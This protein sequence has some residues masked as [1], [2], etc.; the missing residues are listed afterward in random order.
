MSVRSKN[1]K[2]PTDVRVGSRVRVR[3]LMLAMTQEKLAEGLGVSFQQVQNYENGTN[4]I[5]A[6]RLVRVCEILSIS[7]TFVFDAPTSEAK[8]EGT[9][10]EDIDSF[11]ATTQ[12]LAL[13][14]AFMKI[15][16]KATRRTIVALVENIADVQLSDD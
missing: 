14:K 6:S 9:A 13:S 5:S 4:R 3:R 7:P 10:A 2:N 11:F 16:N 15:R 8:A 1:R 12:G